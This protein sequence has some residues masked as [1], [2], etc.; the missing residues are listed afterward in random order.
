MVTEQKNIHLQ[1]LKFDGKNNKV[2]IEFWDINSNWHISYQ[3]KTKDE[4]NQIKANLKKELDEAKELTK[5]VKKQIKLLSNDVSKKDELSFL[6]RYYQHT[7][8][9]LEYYQSQYSFTN[10]CKQ[11]SQWVDF[12]LLKNQLASLFNQNDLLKFLV[13]NNLVP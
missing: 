12:D 3:G 11:Y 13:K 4:L 5:N 2:L 6:E 8:S 9:I 7:L 1:L 10:N